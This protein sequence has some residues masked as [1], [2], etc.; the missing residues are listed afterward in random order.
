ML[1]RSY[2]NPLDTFFGP[3]VEG[4][5]YRALAYLVLG[6]PLGV[7][8]FCA[9]VAML[10]VGFGLTVTIAGLPL[11]WVT[12]RMARGLT[13]F[14]LRTTGALLGVSMP[15]VPATP[16]R[17]RGLRGYFGDREAWANVRYLLLRFPI[18]VAGFTIAVS[19]VASGL[20]F[21]SM[22]ILEADRAGDRKSVV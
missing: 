14:D 13:A 12:L 1:F 22:P 4:R 6:L 21:A 10:A 3:L 19:V 2:A 11:I 16:A 5:T 20:Y 17:K 9:V 8:Y 7:A 15:R 18:G